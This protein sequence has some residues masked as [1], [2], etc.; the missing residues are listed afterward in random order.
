VPLSLVGEYLG[1]HRKLRLAGAEC[2][3]NDDQ[4]RN[5]AAHSGLRY[6][7]AIKSIRRSQVTLGLARDF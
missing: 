7:V 5:R 2:E 1:S 3:I 4:L 6:T